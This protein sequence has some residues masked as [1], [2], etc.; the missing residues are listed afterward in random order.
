MIDITMYSDE[1]LNRILREVTEELAFRKDQKQN[2][3]A[4]ELIK[5]IRNGVKLG[6]LITMI[7]CDDDGSE[8]E[9]PIDVGTK[10]CIG[11]T[12]YTI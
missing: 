8:Y 4:N 3:Y 5:L 2:E 10:F 11:D 12:P 9:E 1:E 7:L 6:Y